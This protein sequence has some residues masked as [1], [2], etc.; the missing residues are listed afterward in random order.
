MQKTREKKTIK[1]FMCSERGKGNHFQ[2]H[3]WQSP[4]CSCK[5]KPSD[6]SYSVGHFQRKEDG[7]VVTAIGAY[8]SSFVKQYFITVTCL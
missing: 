3:I 4:Y 5:N 8:L 2:L 7:M 6:G 1:M